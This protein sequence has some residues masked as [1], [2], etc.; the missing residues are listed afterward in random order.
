MNKN[1]D[2][3][4]STALRDP[5]AYDSY[6]N[7][8]NRFS[9]ILNFLTPKERDLHCSQHRIMLRT[10]QN[11]TYTYYKFVQHHYITNT[12]LGNPQHMF[13]FINSKYTSPFFLNFA[14]CI[15]DTNMQG[16][17]H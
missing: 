9:L 12:P 7:K 11:Y 1:Y 13:T 3:I 14:Y 16:I 6:F 17:I 5:K 15:K 10:K 4:I 2:N 8:Y